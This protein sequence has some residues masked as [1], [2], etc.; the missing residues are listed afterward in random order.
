VFPFDGIGECHQLMHDGKN[1]D[2]NMAVLVGAPREGMKD[3][4]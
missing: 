4:P 2:G 3:V 1:P